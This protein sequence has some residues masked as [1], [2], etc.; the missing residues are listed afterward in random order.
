MY[1][2]ESPNW[3]PLRAG[4]INNRVWDDQKR[5]QIILAPSPDLEQAKVWA[6]YH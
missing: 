1:S 2:A 6:P 5:S 3:N 4:T